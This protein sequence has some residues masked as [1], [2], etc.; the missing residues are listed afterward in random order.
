M[1]ELNKKQVKC[2][3][4]DILVQDVKKYGTYRFGHIL[5]TVASPEDLKRKIH[6]LVNENVMTIRKELREMRKESGVCTECGK[7]KATLKTFTCPNCREKHNKWRVNKKAKLRGKQNE[8]I[9]R[10]H[11]RSG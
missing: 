10:T 1:N 7:K 11:N 9:S 6:S 5:I 8:R 4:N 3:F 2:L